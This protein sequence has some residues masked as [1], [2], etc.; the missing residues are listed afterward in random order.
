MKVP[1]VLSRLQGGEDLCHVNIEIRVFVHEKIKIIG[2]AMSKV[3]STERRTAGE[4]KRQ[5]QPLHDSQDSIL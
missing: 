5:R 1:A 3:M 4:I 2:V